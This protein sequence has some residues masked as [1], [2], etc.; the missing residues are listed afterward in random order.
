[1]IIEKPKKEDL[2]EINKIARQVHLQHV[3]Y[4]PDIYVDVPQVILP[5]RYLELLEKS[6][7][8]VCRDE[9][10]IVGYL[11]T[12]VGEHRTIN[13]F[14]PRKNLLVEAIGVTQECR[15]EGVGSRLMDFAIEM[16]KREKCTEIEL[17]VS[18]EN[19]RAIKFYE[20]HGMRVKNIKYMKKV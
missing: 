7:I 6:Q 10:S 13:G 14:V 5:E 20:K 11:T 3:G 1:M 9:G 16:A 18:P 8:F 4:R 17:T 2:D 15:S 12:T 19:E